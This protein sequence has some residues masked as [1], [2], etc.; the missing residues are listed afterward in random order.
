MRQPL[1]GPPVEV[2]QGVQGHAEGRELDDGRITRV[3]HL[4]GERHLAGAHLDLVEVQ[5]PIDLRGGR[6]VVVAIAHH[7][8]ELVRGQE[9]GQEFFGEI[10]RAV[11]GLHGVGLHLVLEDGLIGLREQVQTTGL[12]EHEADEAEG[13]HEE[14]AAQIRL[15][16]RTE[17]ELPEAEVV[18]TDEQRVLLVG[19]ELGHGDSLRKWGWVKE[20]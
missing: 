10:Q 19:A 15:A 16:P 9:P 20:M 12:D 18:E 14:R 17:H 7:H 8:R 13:D 5:E 2:G 1:L 4:V 11:I 6:G 3:L